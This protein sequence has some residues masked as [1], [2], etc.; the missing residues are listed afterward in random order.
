MAAM[1]NTRGAVV[2]PKIALFTEGYSLF[3]SKFMPE[4]FFTRRLFLKR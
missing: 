3:G 2:N 4:I 1:Q